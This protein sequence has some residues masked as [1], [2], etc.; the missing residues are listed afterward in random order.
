MKTALNLND[1]LPMENNP[2]TYPTLG[3]AIGHAAEVER[4]EIEAW[5][6]MYAAADAGF[7]EAVG[8]DSMRSGDE[9]CLAL[10]LVRGTLLNRSLGIGISAPVSEAAIDRAIDWMHA[11]ALPGWTLEIAAGVVSGA[12]DPL[13][14]WLAARGLQAATG[15]G[16]GPDAGT[17]GMAKFWREPIPITHAVICDLEIREID[18]SAAADFREVAQVGFG[19]PENFARWLGAL[20]GRPRWHTYVAYDGITPAAIATTFIE[21]G[22]AWLGMDATMPGYQRRGV[23]GALLSRRID[24][25]LAR[26]VKGLV[27][28]TEQPEPNEGGE[29]YRNIVRAGFTL[30]HVRVPYVK[31]SPAQ[32]PQ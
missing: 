10:K 1:T 13:P 25:A 3:P 5:F 15:T 12:D 21:H 16:A 17:S 11:H 27:I 9:A 23:Q 24:D 8:L 29:S 2:A 6:D 19:M 18:A 30:S 31:T 4:M 22:L 28:E 32:N 26:G 7:R 20:A 14:Q